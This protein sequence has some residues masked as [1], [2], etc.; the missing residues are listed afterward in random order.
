MRGLITFGILLLFSSLGYSQEDRS[1]EK[2]ILYTKSSQFGLLLHTRGY[3]LD[4]QFTRQKTVNKMF[5][6]DFSL[7]ELRHPKEMLMPNPYQDKSSSYVFGKMNNLVVLK[8]NFGSRRVLGDRF[9]AQDIKVNFNYSF[10]PLVGWMK[11]VYYDIQVINPDGSG[12]SL[13]QQKFD[14]NNITAQQ[15]TMGE[16]SFTKGFNESFFLPGG[17]FKTSLSFEWGN[18]D[19]KFYN[20]ET[21]VMVDAFPTPVPIFAGIK[22]DQV[23]VNLYLCLTYGTRK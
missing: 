6:M 19:Y 21:G 2:N 14:P 18:Y 22:N 12:Y 7:Y 17:N 1:Q 20:L 13:I 15:N 5:L 11:P 4:Y 16:S 9:L 8:M 10:G 3:G 23:F